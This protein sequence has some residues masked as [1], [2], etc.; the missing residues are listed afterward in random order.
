MEQQF[1]KMGGVIPLLLFLY[2]SEWLF[3]VILN[4]IESAGSA[5][6]RPQDKEKKKKRGRT[7]PSSHGWLDKEPC[8]MLCTR[9]HDKNVL[10][11]V[12]PYSRLAP[13]PSQEVW[14]CICSLTEWHP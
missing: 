4:D 14:Q 7:G 5:I 1:E 11:L 12:V 3:K 13:A 9:I 10:L 6:L 2:E 8:F